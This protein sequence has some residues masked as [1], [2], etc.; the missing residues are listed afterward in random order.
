MQLITRLFR[1]IVTLMVFLLSQTFIAASI[2]SF[3][4]LIPMK[5]NNLFDLS[6]Y[7]FFCDTSKSEG[8]SLKDSKKDTSYTK[9][10]HRPTLLKN[11]FAY[12][13]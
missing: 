11:T 1:L 13:P 9:T 10:G 6:S 12:L 5:I 8:N 3:F 4:L 2:Q 7:R